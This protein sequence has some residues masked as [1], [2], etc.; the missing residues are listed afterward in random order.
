MPLS[1]KKVTYFYDSDVGHY[2]GRGHPMK[3]HRIRMAHNMI[4]NNGIY[5]KMEVIRPHKATI[6]EM[7]EFH[8]D[9]YIRFL[10]SI[11][12]DTLPNNNKQ[13]QRCKCNVGE[14][15]SV[16]GG[17]FEFCQISAG[18]SLASAVK[19]NNQSADI[20]I[21]WAG[22]L[23]HAKKSKASS[24]C[25]VNDIV[26]AILEL[27]KH[28]QRVLYIDIDIHHGD[29]VEEAFYTTDRVMTVS[30]HKYGEY[31][32]GA[33]DLRDVGVGKGK[34]YAVNFPLKDGIDDESYTSV[35]VPILQKVMESYQPSAIV[36]Q[37]GA[38][39]LSDDPLGCFN[40][41]LKGHAKCVEFMRSFNL[42]LILLGGG[43]CTRNV[44]RCWTN[45]TAVAL[46]EDINE[47]PYNDKYDNFCRYFKLNIIA[48]NITNQ[49]SPEYLDGV[50]MR[51]LDNLR[52]LP[53]CPSV[54]L[55]DIP[56]DAVNVDESEEV[57][58]AEDAAGNERVTQD[59]V[60]RKVVP[61][62]E[63]EDSDDEGDNKD[64]ASHRDDGQPKNKE[65]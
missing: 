49:N 1:H 24:F 14:D 5:R 18:G 46:G 47:L 21:N 11:T 63:F 19:I 60:D 41:T 58:A 43:G 9:E 27:L 45:E 37:C 62:N 34:H 42:P 33:G 35:F 25:Y 4:M 65:G 48:S 31:F 16:F 8:S 3:P 17:L 61:D 15:C 26:L 40:L 30:F 2:Y 59:Q 56:P 10:R 12:P 51:L 23:H 32:P 57:Q 54:Q 6:A 29:G 39:S 50:R 7:T 44:A 38:D 53:N 28:H 52:L 22:G 13:M 64:E 20:A 55:Q 36:L